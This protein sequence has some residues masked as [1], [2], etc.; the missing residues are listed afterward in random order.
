M[1]RGTEGEAGTRKAAPGDGL[2]AASMS[3]A[4]TKDDVQDT[5][6][7]EPSTVSPMNLHER[8]GARRLCRS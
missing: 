6:A 2:P 5:A 8:E 1:E 3:R 4:G 7:V